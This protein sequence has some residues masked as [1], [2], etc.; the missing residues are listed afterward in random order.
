MGPIGRGQRRS[1]GSCYRRCDVLD[2]AASF[3]YRA[4][5]IAPHSCSCKPPV[6]CSCKPPYPSVDKSSATYGA[7]ASAGPSD[8]PP[9]H[10]TSAAKRDVRSEF[11]SFSSSPKG[12]GAC[13]HGSQQGLLRH[14]QASGTVIPRG[15]P[16]LSKPNHCRILVEGLQ[17]HWTSCEHHALAGIG[18]ATHTSPRS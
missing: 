6:R 12:R 17:G 8:S 11:R 13:A 14:G 4:A 3:A 7:A 16:L 1:G 9:I 18:S 5:R 2:S 15:Q 10:P